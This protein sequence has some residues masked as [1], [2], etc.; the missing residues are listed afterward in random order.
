MLDVVPLVE[1]AAPQLPAPQLELPVDEVV[2]V[3][4][5][6]APLHDAL[7]V[8]PLVD[9]LLVSVVE[10]EL[11]PLL[12]LPPPH[13][14]RPRSAVAATASVVFVLLFIRRPFLFDVV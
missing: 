10:P 2:V 1:P 3:V 12:L 9:E 11:L 5:P 14:V 13:A 8:P 6:L 4:E 7:P